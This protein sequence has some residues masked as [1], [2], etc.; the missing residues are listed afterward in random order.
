MTDHLSLF[1]CTIRCSEPNSQLNC[2]SPSGFNFCPLFLL[3]ILLSHHHQQGSSVLTFWFYICHPNFKTVFIY[4]F[5]I[6]VHF[7]VELLQIICGMIRELDV[8]R[9]GWPTGDRIIQIIIFTWTITMACRLSSISHAQSHP[10]Q[11]IFLWTAKLF[12]FFSF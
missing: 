9:D 8:L 2:V 5:I 11:S 7:C 12:L 1:I 10:F 4:F 3:F 6:L